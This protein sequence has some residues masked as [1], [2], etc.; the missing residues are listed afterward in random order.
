MGL[1]PEGILGGPNRPYGATVHLLARLVGELCL[2]IQCIEILVFLCPAPLGGSG[3][4]SGGE[5]GQHQ[6]QRD[7]GPFH[8]L[9]IDKFL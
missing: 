8:G 4:G 7:Y 9:G 3:L 2:G 6:R 1:E 5:G